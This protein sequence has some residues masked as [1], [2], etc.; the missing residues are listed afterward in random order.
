MTER[1]Q[2]DFRGRRRDL[3]LTFRLTAPVSLTLLGSTVSYNQAAPGDAGANATPGVGASGGAIY[4]TA[5]GSIIDTTFI[6]NYAYCHSG[7][8]APNGTPVT[9]SNSTFTDNTSLYDGGAIDVVD[10]GHRHSFLPAPSTTTRK[11][12]KASQG[13][14]D[15]G[16][17]SSLSKFE[18]EADVT[19]STFIRQH[20]PVRRSDCQ[21]RHRSN[22]TTARLRETPRQSEPA[23][24]KPHSEARLGLSR[25]IT[26]SLPQTFLP[27]PSPPLSMT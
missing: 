16:N 10:G 6:G 22:S 18:S 15:G 12:I 5:G 7:I 25:A 27:P 19:N 17:A 8:S 14:G 1:R 11:P 20:R 9:I 4:S 13:S 26:R 2:D 24:S 3:E 23:V 21:P